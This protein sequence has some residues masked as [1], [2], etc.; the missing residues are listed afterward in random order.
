MPKLPGPE[1]YGAEPTPKPGTGVATFAPV[2]EGIAAPGLAMSQ[3]GRTIAGVG[4]EIAREQ[5][6]ID[7]VKVEDA[8]NRYKNAAL[9]LTTGEGG[10]LTMKG[11]DAVNGNL[12]N[13]AAGGLN[14]KRTEIVDSLS[15][16]EQR[17]RFA[18]RADLTDLQ[19]KSQ[20]LAHLETEHAAY[21]K[22]VFTGSEAAAR[23]QVAAMPTDPGVFEGARATVMGQADAFL[24][25]QGVRDPQARQAFKD[26]LNDGLWTTRIDT[27]LYTQPVMADALFR[28][29]KDQ[30]KNP[31]QRLLLQA[32]TREA[33]MAVSAA[34]EAGKVIDEVRT[35]MA[36]APRARAT[37][38]GGPRAPDELIAT[39]IQQESGGNPQAVS[40]KGARGL[41][42]VMPETAKAVAARLGLPYDEKLL[43]ADT[44]EGRAYNKTLGTDYL[45]TQLQRFGGNQTLALAA[46]NAGPEVVQDWID[47]TNVSGKNRNLV[48]LGDPNTGETS[49]AAFAAGIPFAETRN[50]VTKIN[51]KSPPGAMVRVSNDPL[52]QPTSGLPNS[53]DIAAQLP[54]MMAKVTATADRLY[55]D[56]QGNPDRA[57]FIRRMTS[58]L[59]AKVAADVQQ[60]NAIQRQAQGTLIDAITGVGGPAAKGDGLLGMSGGGQANAPR[61][62]ITSFGQIQADPN[63][64]RA[65]QFLD[66][67]AKVSLERLMEHNLRANDKGDVVLYR[68]LFNRIHLEPGDPKKIDFYQQIVDPK[69][70]DRLSMQQIQQLRTELDRNETPGGRSLNQL[71]KAADA[72]VALYF[73]TNVMFTAQPER[74]I[75]ATMRWTEDAGKKIDEYVKAGKDVRSLFMLDS[76]DS[77]I[78][79]RYLQTYVNSTPAVGVAAGAA[80][81]KDGSAAPVASVVTQP[82]TIDTREKLDAWFKTL[83]PTVDRFMGTDGKVR[84]IPGRQ[85]GSQSAAAPAGSPNLGTTPPGPVETVVTPTGKIDEKPI[86]AEV[87]PAMPE[88]V[89][90]QTMAERRAAQEVAGRA[91]WGKDVQRVK[92]SGTGAADM[93]KAV[94]LAPLEARGELEAAGR[95][96]IV[97]ALTPDDAARAVKSFREMITAGR[98]TAQSI[99]LIEDAVASGQLTPGEMRVARRML[100]RISG[101]EKK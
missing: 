95:K 51:R 76:P 45:N 98:Y 42:Q 28:A 55:G 66:P 90:K 94:V 61:M 72:N 9:D 74:Q 85:A 70:A 19:T 43:T 53:R 27:L 30:I 52:A 36:T 7:T 5:E 93:L 68:E 58:E 69:V 84:L 31:E 8:W 96:A 21:E 87:E 57:A 49:D 56:D 41:M 25:S 86:P 47:G 22:T 75:A 24:N 11:A 59:H 13:R 89:G 16:D 29:N 20:V 64:M 54:V 67:A 17:K 40:P 23:A 26:K 3:L 62:L 37:P 14:A 32:K 78:S 2:G 35:S 18:A 39:V 82:G 48:R 33:S 81:V 63:L 44:P 65:W 15:T 34:I 73:K 50:Y 6:K 38:E 92:E 100:E 77:I 12:L 99:P 4:E 46:Y 97:K 91:Q 10:V 60:L 83:P 101:G 1:V 80:A 71:R 79:P 88:L